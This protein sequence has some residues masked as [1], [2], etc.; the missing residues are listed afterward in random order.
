MLDLYLGANQFQLTTNY[1]CSKFQYVPNLNRICLSLTVD[2]LRGNSED[3]QGEILVIF[4]MSYTNYF[5]SQSWTNICFSL[6]LLE[7]V[8]LSCL[9]CRYSVMRSSWRFVELFGW[10]CLY[11][12]HGCEGKSV[13]RKLLRSVAWFISFK[14]IRIFR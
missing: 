6:H 12:I 2:Y 10:T 1:L 8:I 11:W 4:C 3:L 13:L 14:C 5:H 7:M 9:S